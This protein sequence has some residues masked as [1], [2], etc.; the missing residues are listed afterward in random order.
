[1]A[2]L[3]FSS[4]ENVKKR[5]AYESV[6]ISY[7]QA[8]S[9]LDLNKNKVVELNNFGLGKAD[10]KEIFLFNKEVKGNTG[11][12]GELSLSFV[13]S[14]LDKVEV[15][16]KK[17]FPVLEEIIKQNKGFKIVLKVDCEGAEYE[18][19]ED[20]DASGILNQIDF[21]MIDWYDKGNEV[22]EKYY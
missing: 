3:F 11:S 14:N 21:A 2:S 18:I 17:A 8:K 13:E 5:Y 4:K 12:R 10:K 20:L 19:F 9:N 7:S 22:L 15:S 16:I 6:P 1:M